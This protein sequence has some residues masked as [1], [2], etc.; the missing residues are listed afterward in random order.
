MPTQSQR[1]RSERLI[2]G[3]TGRIGSG[4]TSVGK[5]LN[6]AHAFQYLRYSQVLSDWLAQD[7]ERK[8]HLQEIGWEVMAG[9]MQSELNSRL[10]AQITDEADVAVDGLRHP[11]DFKS[12][13]K[14]FLRS[15]HLLYIDSPLEERWRRLKS[16]D[17]QRDLRSFEIIDSHPVEQQIESLRG[18]ADSVIQNDGSLQDLYDLVDEI[19]RGFRKEGN[20]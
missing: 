14:S 2:F 15:F 16:R 6:S 5:Y 7:P 10:I 4:K 3:I 19:I 8:S 18:Y 12:L 20:K 17:R 13:N 11:V 1:S 9:G